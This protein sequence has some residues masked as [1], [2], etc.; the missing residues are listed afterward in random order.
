[1][2]EHFHFLRPEYLV[3]LPVVWPL[4]L[5][6]VKRQDET[7]V[8]KE[9][10][11]ADLLPYLFEKSKSHLVKA[12]LLLGIVMSLML[13]AISGPAYKRSA[14]QGKKI[15][16]EI[17]FVLKVS[18]SMQRAD[19]MP[20]RLSRAVL[21]MEDVLEKNSDMKT[22]LIA[23]NGSAHLVMPLIQD[24]TIIAR[25]A[26][27]LSPEIMPKKGDALYEALQLASQQFHKIEGTI[28][29]LT[30]TLSK[31]E[32]EKI[33]KDAALQAY[34]IV[35]YNITSKALQQK[36]I[37]KLTAKMGADFVA[38]S[39]DGSDIESI[40]ASVARQYENAQMKKEGSYVDSGY[41]LVPFIALF[42]LLFF[43]K[44]FLSHL[45]SLR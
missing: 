45:W 8:Y 25:F 31:A 38:F 28:I 13:L 27:S 29:I 30:D 40:N 36:S 1:M 14:S 11:D 9:I 12:P 42:L 37:E 22:A 39:S 7:R 21:K 24:S 5:W 41:E 16:S 35:L 44:G 19:L 43:R 4:V 18:K 26:H 6:L 33:E 20:S 2:F 34:K 32:V 10:V 17:V 3:L 15:E 23:Y